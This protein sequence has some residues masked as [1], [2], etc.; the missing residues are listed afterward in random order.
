MHPPGAGQLVAPGGAMTTTL[1]RPQIRHV[2]QNHHLD[3]HRWDNFKPRRGDVVISTSYKAGTT[4]MQTIVVNMIF[5]DGNLPGPVASVSPWLDMTLPPLDDTLTR[6]EA[7]THRRCL[8]SHLAL[9]GLRYFDEVKYIMVGR[10]P[11]DV[12]MSLLNHYGNHTPDFYAAM[13]GRPDR[14][15]DPPG[16]RR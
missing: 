3:S 8:K 7:Q 4:L 10:D 14:V 9:D 15:G 2:Y 6:L 16:I 13:N 12:F 1:K 5:P 11:R